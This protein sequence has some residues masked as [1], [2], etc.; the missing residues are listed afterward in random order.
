[1]STKIYNGFQINSPDIHRVMQMIKNFRPIAEGYAFALAKT[2]MSH[3]VQDVTSRIKTMDEWFERR[4]AV[5]QLRR[6]PGVDTQFQL[7][8]FPYALHNCFYGIAYVDHEPW[9]NAWL[10][11]PGVSYFGYWNNTD[12]PENISE[13]AWKARGEL[14]DELLGES[15]IPSMAGLSI[16]VTNPRGPDMWKLNEIPNE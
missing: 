7:L 13:E 10:E 16:E 14:W 15:G 3:G 1:M 6:D 9:F 11:Q 12:G 4:R 5:Q 2:F 8:L